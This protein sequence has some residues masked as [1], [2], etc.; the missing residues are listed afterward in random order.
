MDPKQNT[1]DP[2]SSSP[3]D[4][5]EAPKEAPET[6]PEEVDEAPVATEFQ[7]KVSAISESR[8]QLLQ[9][10]SGILV[11]AFTIISLVTGGTESFSMPFII[12]LCLAFFGPNY[13]EKQGGRSVQK[14]RIAMCITIAVGVVVLLLTFGVR[15]HFTFKD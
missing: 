10:V 14:A 15:T 4:I 8:W 12:A 13:I 7:K 9:I 2:E 3:T 1:Q 6:I 5:I 11:G